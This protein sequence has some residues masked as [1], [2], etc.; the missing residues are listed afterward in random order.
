MSH[1]LEGID[2]S[3]P[4]ASE[5]SASESGKF[6]N[7]GESQLFDALKTSLAPGEKEL[8]LNR[9]EAIYKIEI[10]EKTAPDPEAKK[11]FSAAL[12]ILQQ[13]NPN[14]HSLEAL[15]NWILQLRQAPLPQE[16]PFIPSISVKITPPSASSEP[17]LQHSRQHSK[18]VIEREGI[19]S[20]PWIRWVRYLFTGEKGNR[21]KRPT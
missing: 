5:R 1:G 7:N 14:I 10:L 8:S 15:K 21:N 6:R 17:T 4:L 13:D 16:A 19:L 20:N 12:Q 11:V 18:K 3:N 9:D 2:A